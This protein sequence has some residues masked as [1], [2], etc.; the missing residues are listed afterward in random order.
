MSKADS[1]YAHPA[2]TRY[3]HLKNQ[4][5]NVA[6]YIHSPRNIVYSSW[7]KTFAWLPVTTMDKQKVWLKPVYRRERKLLQ[8]IPQFPVK[9]LDQTQWATLDYILERKLEGLD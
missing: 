9:A 7:V 3:P 4:Y 1:K 5:N 6:D 2:Y 8:D